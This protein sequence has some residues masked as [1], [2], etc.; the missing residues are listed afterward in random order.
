MERQR[1]GGGSGGM[2][3]REGGN[4]EGRDEGGSERK[5]RKKRRGCEGM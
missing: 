2:Y 1:R 4:I 3:R 5:L